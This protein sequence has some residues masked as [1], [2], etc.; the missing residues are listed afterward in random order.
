MK[1]STLQDLQKRRNNLYC[2]YVMVFMLFMGF[3]SQ[4]VSAQGTLVPA[5]NLI[6]PLEACAVADPNDTSGDIIINVDVARSGSPNLV[7]ATTNS[8]FTYS[9][10]SNS[11]GAFIRSYGPVVYN[12]GTNRTTQTLILFPGSS[13][14]EFNLRLDVVNTSSN[15]GT[16]SAPIR[17]ICDCSKSVSV[18]KVAATASFSPILCAGQTSTLTVIGS[19]SDVGTYNYTLLP[20]GPTNSTGVFPGLAGSV[21]G[22]TYTVSVESAEGCVTTASQTI[23]APPANPIILTCPT[24]TTAGSCLTQDGVNSLFNAW[25][26]TFSFSGGTNG[27]AVRS[28]LNPTAPPRCGGSREVTWTVT[29]DCDQRETC[30]RTFSV[31]APP[32]VSL[33]CPSNTT[34]TA[35]QTQAAVDA[36]YATWLA[37]ATAS[38]GCNGSL[39][40]NSQ[41]APPACGGSRTV[42]FT[43][44]SSCEPLTS[45]C[46]ATFTVPNSP[47]VSLTCPSNTTT[48]ACQTQEAVDAAYAAWLATATASGGCGGSLTNNSTGAPL[49]CGGSK[50]VTF[51]YSNTCSE[52]PSTCQATFTVP[53]SPTVTLTCPSNTTTTACQTQAAVD[54][55]YA[56]W[57]ATASATGGCNGTLRNDSQGA[58]PACGGSRTVTF[59]YASS[60]APL[61]ST[62]Q[63]TFTLPNSPTV[64]LTCPTNSSIAGGQTQAAV[65]AAYAAWLATATASGGC[66]GSLTNN[67]TGAPLACGDSK[68]VT[69]TYTSSCAPLTTTCQATFTVG[70]CIT[71]H[72]FPTQ[73]TCCNFVTGTATG[74]TT[75]CTKLS[76]RTVNNAIPGVFFYYSNV[77]APSSNFVIVVKQ[78]NDGDLNKL[79]SIQNTQNVRL[80]T[81]AC[82]SV[83]F[84]GSMING[85]KDARYVVTGATP[86]ATYVV[87]VKYDTKSIIE[88]VYTGPDNVSKYTFGSYVNNVLDTTS[89]GTIDAVA[90]C[91]DNTPLPGDCSLPVAKQAPTKVVIKV[92]PNP[93]ADNFKLNVISVSEEDLQIKVFDMLGKTIDSRSVKMSEIDNFELGDNYPSGIYNV[94]V[95]Q[96]TEVKTQR[97]IKR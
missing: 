54:A 83:T 46:Q 31:Q 34:T 66:N 63:A 38:G 40:N 42:T 49:A 85:N 44:T 76:G 94:S 20:S 86:G 92:Y 95:S 74:L 58:P 57:L 8:N 18:S 24:T 5:C 29:D 75:A 32:A 47:T 26:G 39:T 35:C 22:I 45:S 17:T 93:T 97:V 2:C 78:S 23:T 51:S 4:K 53:N 89:V 62:C 11:S 81:S 50:T 10:Q 61:T 91:S 14:S 67:S 90:G 16:E 68:T 41:G 9:F 88:A 79:F 6:G 21:V 27:V 65:N 96:G 72:I 59:T 28:P 25:L 12:A 71:S 56:T 64:S 60:C 13:T 87:S 43:Y 33:T 84:T 55:A 19:F 80:T 7:N 48:T 37:T 73:T 15:I 82:G 52:T 69:F 3:V 70:S 30:T 1:N 36:A 77:V